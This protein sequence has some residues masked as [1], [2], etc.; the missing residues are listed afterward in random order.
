MNYR[1]TKPPA[2]G[3]K[4]GR[5]ELTEEQKQEVKEAFDLFDTEGTGQIDVKE[6]KVA[7]RALGF[8]PKKEEVR[9][10]ISEVDKEGRG[11]ID[12]PD[13]MDL[14]TI[15]MVKSNLFRLKEILLKK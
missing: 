8:E 9:K 6:L 5:N 10:M 11:V 15:K 3:A 4:R 7:M 1:S 14:M 13:F 12:F 2:K